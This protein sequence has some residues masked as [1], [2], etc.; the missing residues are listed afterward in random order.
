MAQSSL[1]PGPGVPVRDALGPYLMGSASAEATIDGVAATAGDWKE[2]PWTSAVQV[3]L[4]LGAIGADVS[5]IDIEIQAADAEDAD[6]DPDAIVRLGRF[7]AFGP[8]DDNTSAVLEVASYHRY[9]RAVVNITESG[10]DDAVGLAI[11]LVSP[12]K[13]R[14]E[15]VGAGPVIDS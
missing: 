9:M 3:L 8:T 2:V 15:A 6:G 4:E 1:T 14:G 11:S 7:G 12:P 10:D 5:D 13:L